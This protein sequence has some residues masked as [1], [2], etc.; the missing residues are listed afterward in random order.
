MNKIKSKELD[1]DF[2]GGQGPLT[3]D[4]E[5]TISEFLKTQKLLKSKAEVRKRNSTLKVK[6]TAPI[7][8]S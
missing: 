4:E 2:I 6:E 3:K 7:E 1:V 8:K 5:R